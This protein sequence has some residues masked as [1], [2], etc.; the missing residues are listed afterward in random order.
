MRSVDYPSSL[1]TFIIPYAQICT[2]ALGSSEQSTNHLPWEV[3]DSSPTRSQSASSA[4]PT[5]NSSSP[6]DLPQ[7]QANVST[8]VFPYAPKTGANNSLYLTPNVTSTDGRVEIKVGV[9][10][11]YSL[12]NNLT[13]QLAYS[14]TS[15]IRL[16]ASEINQNKLIPGA[17]IT[18][19]LKDS[20]NG[21]DPENS[22]AAQAIF[23]TVSLLQTDGGVSGVIGD[24]SSALTAQSA[25]L[26]SRLSIPQCSY[27][28][29][30]TQLSN[31]ED[32]G[33][34]F[35]TIPTEPMFGHVMIDFVVNRGWRT[36]AVF[37]T[38]DAL[39]SGMMNNIERQAR[40]NGITIGY[41]RTFWEMGTSSDVGPGLDG[42]KDSGQQ[43]ILVA[44]VGT[45]QVRLIMEAVRRGLVSKNYVWLTINQITEPLLG[46]EGSTLEPMDLNGLFMF[47]NMLRLHGYPPYEAFLDRWAALDPTEY[48]YAGKRDISSNE[49]Q[50]YS[51]MMVMANGFAN[52]VKGNSTALRM[53]ASGKLGPK[54]TPLN[55]NTNYTGPGGPMAF[56]EDGDVVYG[57]FILYNFQNGRVVEIG[58]SYS[59]F[60][61]LSSSPMYY[62]GTYN[63]PSD[64]APLKVLNPVFSS[65]IAI[66][67][68]IVAGL[69]ITGLD[70][71]NKFTCI[72]R[73]FTL[74]VG[75]ILV[76]SNIVA[77]NFR[78]YRIFHNIYVTKKVITDSHLL[79]IVGAILAVNLTVMII[80]FLRTPPTLEQIIMQDLTTYWDCSSQSGKM[81][82]PQ[83]QYLTKFFLTNV[84]LL[85]G[86]T[87]SLMFMFLP[88]LMKLYSQIECG[89]QGDRAEI[90]EES[91][92]NGLFNRPSWLNTSSGIGSSMGEYVPARKGSVVSIED[93]KGDTLR[94]SHFGYMGV[95]FQ[96]RYMPFLSSW[97][98]RRI[99]LFP[100][101]KYF[102]AFESGKPEAGR[103]FTFRAVHILS[104]E[105]DN[106]ILQVTGHGRLDFLLQVED[107]DHLMYW[108]SLF[109][110]KQGNTFTSSPMG[111]TTALPLGNLPMSL[112]QCRTESDQTLHP[113]YVNSGK[114]NRSKKG[115]G[116]EGCYF[117][118]TTRGSSSHSLSDP[119]QYQQ[120][121]HTSSSYTMASFTASPRSSFGE[122]ERPCTVVDPP[123]RQT[124]LGPLDMGPDDFSDIVGDSSPS[125]TPYPSDA[126]L[127]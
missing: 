98:M 23:S 96:N 104:K 40:K 48:P 49:A 116:D 74:N 86:T 71:P 121:C 64:T 106:Y 127:L 109:E 1:T 75:F 125:P 117:S 30:S 99:V 13:Q 45:P 24:V 79:K 47:D 6:M 85:F 4:T 92:F 58:T 111:S 108:Y 70:I 39:G 51:C 103:T 102:T 18:L 68:I 113:P 100:A 55:M 9:L 65:P 93:S 87:V 62:D 123:S 19:V 15:A 105:P 44:A 25:L 72:L 38:G 77:K 60:L 50:A 53:L 41:R 22:G 54:L 107:E 8:R 66:V 10:L 73:P 16:A 80:W 112:A 57:N 95:K 26:T 35:R 37:Y 76:V 83:D 28:A 5:A 42:L 21:L 14:G 12:P 27:S 34:F 61:T 94:E 78:V 56:G 126:R 69:V 29:G 97:C 119:Y 91:S 52:A 84:V 122:V 118:R 59:G 2:A 3:L 124:T 90:A 81:F 67:I 43:I 88:K 63:A 101:E 17:Y 7:N 20:F 32:Y 89:M 120:H 114:S 115:S 11:P 31:K 110:F 36:I 33:H 46:M 82:L